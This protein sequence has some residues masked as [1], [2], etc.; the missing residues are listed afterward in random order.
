MFQ[1]DRVR[2]VVHETKSLMPAYNSLPKADLDNLL[3][4]LDS[5]RGDVRA[6][7]DVKKAEGIR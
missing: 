2:E 4:Y 6:G 7:A 3:A 1:K 5:L